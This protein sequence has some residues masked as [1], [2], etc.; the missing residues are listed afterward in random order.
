MVGRPHKFADKNQKVFTMNEL[1]AVWGCGSETIYK[2]MDDGMPFVKKDGEYQFNLQEC[3]E[4][5]AHGYFDSIPESQKKCARRFFS[6][7]E[8]IGGIKV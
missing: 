3:Q 6:K 7:S 5:W 8:I 1:M 4:W 2:A